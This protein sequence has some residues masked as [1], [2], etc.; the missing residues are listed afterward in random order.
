MA[1]TSSSH[2]SRLPS[3]V[4]NPRRHVGV[5]AERVSDVTNTEYPGHYPDE[6]HS[7]DLS[8]FKKTLQVSVKRLSQRSV[9]FDLVGV[10]ASIANAFRRILIAEVPTIAIEHVYVWNN[11]SVIHDEVLAHRIGLIPLNVKPSHFDFR[12]QNDLP[13]DRN[14]LVFRLQVACERDKNAPKGSASPY[15][16]EYAKSGDLIWVP[17]GE[18]ESVFVNN[19]PAPT[20]KDIVLAKLRPGQEIDMELHGI[21]GVGKDHAKWSP[22]ATASY[23]LHPL[24]LL[25]PSKPVPAHLATKFTNCFSTGVVKVDA[26]GKVSIDERNLRKESMSREVL[27][28][29]EFEGCVE[30]KRIRD[31][32]IF[33]VESEGPYAPEALFPEAIKDLGSG[34]VVA[35][36]DGDVE[37]A[38]AAMST[39]ALPAFNQSAKF[40]YT[41]SPNP[42]FTYGQKVDTTTE[43][44]EWL[45]GEKAG[46][47]LVDTSKEDPLKL[48]A[49]MISGIVPRPIAFISSISDAGVENLAPFSWFNMVSHNPPVISVSCSNVAGR[50]KDTARNVKATKGFTVNIIIGEWPLSGLTKEPSIKVKPPRVKE[51]AFSL[52]CELFQAIDIVHPET[53][54]ATTT[55]ILGLV[56]CVHVRNDML[57]ERG[58]IDPAK[59]KAVGRMGD[60]SYCRVGDGF[61][62]TRPAWKLEGESIQEFLKGLDTP[63]AQL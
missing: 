16:N 43:G 10:D 6:D 25:N 38:G 27:R 51:S 44:K 33:D 34:A 24:I 15:I 30:L 20:N 62:L 4:F 36:G 50:L 18:Q 32:F 46:W 3:S 40:Q 47:K 7:W 13:T 5:H 55:L 48:Y 63:A 17:Q 49:L 23:R 14:T 59:Y 45:E 8:K 21:K 52:E 57:N 9:E 2:Q 61:R 39:P 28:H 29:K 1:S 37:M 31:W 35:D 54:V 19:I 22:V 56:K 26:D 12:L 41:E 60:I 42:S 11:T 58:I 53:G